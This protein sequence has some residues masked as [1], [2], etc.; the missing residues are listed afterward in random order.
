MP[1]SARGLRARPATTRCLLVPPWLECRRAPGFEPA[2]HPI[3]RHGTIAALHC[4]PAAVEL[5]D[6]VMSDLERNANLACEFG[7]QVRH[8][9][10]PLVRS[11]FERDCGGFVDFDGVS[12]SGH[13]DSIAERRGLS[14]TLANR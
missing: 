12:L 6:L 11:F 3:V 5:G 14:R 8:G 1:R 10:P 13:V 9:Q 4:E 7:Q 2:H